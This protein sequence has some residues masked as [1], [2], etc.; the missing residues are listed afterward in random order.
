MDE[1]PHGTQL[2]CLLHPLLVRHTLPLFSLLLNFGRRQPGGVA[3]LLPVFLVDG[4]DLEHA[5][6]LYELLS[7]VHV[8]SL[9]ESDMFPLFR[10]LS[11]LTEYRIVLDEV[12]LSLRNRPYKS[13][14]FLP[15]FIDNF[16]CFRLRLGSES[17]LG[18]L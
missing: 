16:S 14:L 8:P 9:R 10:M 3:A 17:S 18:S 11:A 2:G 1:V 13:N 5:T 12:L 6:P 4:V 15:V 7:G